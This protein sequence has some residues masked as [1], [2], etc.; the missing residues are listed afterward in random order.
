[1]VER[2]VSIVNVL[3]SSAILNRATAGIREIIT[4]RNAMRFGWLERF[5]EDSCIIDKI[6]MVK[7]VLKLPRITLKYQLK[8][9][10]NE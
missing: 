1:V 9:K 7:V 2:S 5:Q 6:F 10:K 3:G 4:W 8:E